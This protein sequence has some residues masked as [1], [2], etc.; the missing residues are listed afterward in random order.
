MAR[1]HE[2]SRSCPRTENAGTR[3]TGRTTVPGLTSDLGT[4]RER[5]G[6]HE[7]DEAD[8]ESGTENIRDRAHT[9]GRS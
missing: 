6:E 2:R 7:A 8:E 9:S 3:D 4:N 5:R 1:K